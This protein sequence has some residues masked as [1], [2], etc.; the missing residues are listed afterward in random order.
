MSS[1]QLLTQNDW[2]ENRSSSGSKMVYVMIIV[3]GISLL[4]FQIIIE[5]SCLTPSIALSRMHRLLQIAS[6]ITIVVPAALLVVDFA[7]MNNNN[8]AKFP[9]VLISIVSL[10]SISLLIVG[11]LAGIEI[12]HKKCSTVEFPVY[13]WIPVCL[14]V[15][16]TISM[17]VYRYKSNSKISIPKQQIDWSKVKQN[18]KLIESIGQKQARACG[19]EIE[20]GA[21]ILALKHYIS[22]RDKEF[23][24]QTNPFTRLFKRP[25]TLP[26]DRIP[27]IIKMYNQLEEDFNEKLYQRDQQYTKPKTSYQSRDAEDL[28]D[29]QDEE[30]EVIRGPIDDVGESGF[31][32]NVANTIGNGFWTGV[33][34]VTSLFNGS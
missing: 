26:K 13:A 8:V 9:T 33:Q 22:N 28:R 17:S 19:I 10:A 32:N 6:I 27:N 20:Q 7:G 34:A 24:S 12:E 25:D 18:A 14:L 4:T 21:S 15:L 2:L 3:I 11:L 31:L 16:L 1:C 29:L 23:R 5:K 30:S